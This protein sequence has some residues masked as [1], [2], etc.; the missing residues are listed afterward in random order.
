MKKP[1][2]APQ[3]VKVIRGFVRKWAVSSTPSET[4]SNYPISSSWAYDHTEDQNYVL[5]VLLWIIIKL[6]IQLKLTAADDD[7][8]EYLD[9]IDKKIEDI[10]EYI[11]FTEE[12]SVFNDE[13]EDDEEDELDG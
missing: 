10:S 2:N 12:L 1:F 7:F 4:E 9:E 6:I 11:D 5:R 8:E 13:L 3:L